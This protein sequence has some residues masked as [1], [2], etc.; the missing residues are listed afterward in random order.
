MVQL[1]INGKQIQAPEGATVL[2]A[3]KMAGIHIPTLCA[4]KELAPYGGCRLCIVDV[5][6][7]RVPMAACTLPVS[8]GMIAYDIE[9]FVRS[10]PEA[11]IGLY[12]HAERFPLE[13]TVRLRYKAN[14]P[15]LVSGFDELLATI[16]RK[17]QLE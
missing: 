12:P 5:E 1:T 11:R 2:H 7:W 8:E 3:A 17:H 16:K 6:K 14:D 9:Q 4:H 13:V 15:E 10:H